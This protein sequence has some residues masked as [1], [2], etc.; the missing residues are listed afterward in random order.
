MCMLYILGHP[1]RQVFQCVCVCVCVC[2]DRHLLAYSAF[3]HLSY[4]S[5]AHHSLSMGLGSSQYCL[6]V[7]GQETEMELCRNC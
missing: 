3:V 4:C 7:H 5:L 6:L 1:W 2:V